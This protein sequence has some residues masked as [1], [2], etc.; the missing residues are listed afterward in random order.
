MRLLNNYQRRVNEIAQEICIKNPSMLRSR[1][2]L[3]ELA[4]A[5]VDESY[6][7]KKGKVHSKHYKLMY[8]SCTKNKQTNHSMR[9]V[10]MTILEDNIK[11]YKEKRRQVAEDNKNYHLCDELTEEIK[12]LSTEKRQHVAKL[13]LLQKKD[14]FS[15]S[16][17]TQKLVSK[18]P[19]VSSS[20]SKNETC[21]SNSE[22]DTE[23]L[24]PIIRE[25]SH[26]TIV[27]S[28]NSSDQKFDS[29]FCQCLPTRLVGRPDYELLHIIV[30]IEVNQV[31]THNYLTMLHLVHLINYHCRSTAKHE[32]YSIYLATFHPV[33]NVHRCY[34]WIEK[35]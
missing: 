34:K 7:F 23:A 19:S 25:V 30:N 35:Y 13:K 29:N 6:Q 2:K 17:H 11:L 4:C 32:N 14:E 31:I 33:L 24:P 12:T 10:R 21:N 1:K 27:L 8:G 18:S 15:K 22:E 9:L 28:E 3:L 26:D 20:A 16:Y 5:R